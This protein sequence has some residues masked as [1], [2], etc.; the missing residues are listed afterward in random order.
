[1][2]P[3]R[4]NDLTRVLDRVVKA[5]SRSQMWI[6]GTESRWL[7]PTWV[8]DRENVRYPSALR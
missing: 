8:E 3:L 7:R 2:R 5:Q 6:E 1:M 4:Q